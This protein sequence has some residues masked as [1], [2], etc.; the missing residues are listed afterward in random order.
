MKYLIIDIETV[1]NKEIGWKPPEK[2]PN[3]FPPTFAH[4]IVTIGGMQLN[5]NTQKCEAT[6]LGIFGNCATHISNKYEYDILHGFYNKF[7][8]LKEG[9]QTA[10]VTYNGRAFDI[11]VIIARMLHYGIRCPL[12]LTPNFNYRYTLEGHIDLMD[13][14]TNF[15][16]SRWNKLIHVCRA[17]GMPGKVGTDGSD[18]QRLWDQGKLGEIIEYCECD[19]IQTGIVLLRCL[20]Q[21]EQITTEQYNTTVK[22]ILDLTQQKEFEALNKTISMMDDNTLFLPVNTLEQK[23]ADQPT[24]EV[25]F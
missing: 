19:V 16:A 5:I 2:K 9:S 1:N 13:Y 8:E 14:I 23:E 11:P 18:V 25:P 15:G 20:H 12:L 24:E 4:K 10:I 6:W 7:K 3:E 22:S 21:N 17:I